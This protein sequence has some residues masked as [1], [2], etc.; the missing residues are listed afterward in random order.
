[1]KIYSKIV[2]K[3]FNIIM[4]IIAFIMVLL[5]SEDNTIDLNANTLRT[6]SPQGY[7]FFTRDPKEPQLFIYEIERDTITRNLSQNSSSFNMLFGLSRVNR[8]Q[9]LEFNEVFPKLI[10]WKNYNSITDIKG[11]I[12]DS[13]NIVSKDSRKINGKFLIIRESRI[14]W[15]WA[16][17]LKKPKRKFKLIYIQ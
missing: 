12:P 7:A 9:S 16:S 8:R 1:M 11:V 2:Q 10:K 13:L 3:L 6:I 5:F 14:P 4:I 15:A 17:N